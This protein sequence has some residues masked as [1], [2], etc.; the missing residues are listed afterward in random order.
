[1]RR[2]AILALC[3]FARYAAASCSIGVPPPKF[4]V[5][6]DAQCKY[7][8][9]QA[10]IK[11]V[12]SPTSCAPTI[13]VTNEHQPWNE[14]L[15]IDGRS[16]TLA[17]IAGGCGVSSTGIEGAPDSPATT[18]TSPQATISG[19]GKN[20]P[21]ITISGNSTVTLQNLE[22]TGG[23]MTENSQGAGINFTGSGSL[24]LNATTVDGNKADY[25]AGI[26]MSPSGSATLTLQAY[27]LIVNNQAATSGG[28]IRIEGN[29][30]L[31]AVSDQTIITDNT[32]LGADGYGGGIEIFAPAYANIGSPGYGLQGVV[33]GNTAAYGGGIAVH[34]T[35]DSGESAYLQMFTTVAERPVA[36]EDNVATVMGGGIYLEP[37][38][39]TVAYSDAQMCLFDFRVDGN[40]APEGAAIALDNIKQ[41]ETGDS[42]G[43]MNLNVAY[44]A[45]N[46]GPRPPADFNAIPCAADTACN[47][48]SHNNPPP[49]P[50]PNPYKPTGGVIFVGNKD[51]FVG[52]RFKLQ[53][54]YADYGMHIL[55]GLGYGA[56]ANSSAYACLFT[57][58][59][60]RLN[61]VFGDGDSF[62]F[63]FINCTMAN[64]LDEYGYVFR[65]GTNAE[66][67]LH[68]D[69]FDE[70]GS[71]TVFPQ[72]DL[73]L[74]ASYILANDTSTLSTA[75]SIVELSASD[76]LFVDAAHG[77]Y[78]LIAAMQ[79][80]S[81]IATAAI[82]FA[83][84]DGDPPDDLDGNTYGQDVPIIPN[85][86]GTRD[87]GAYEAQPITDRI[88]G[89]AFGDILLIAK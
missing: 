79:N 51:V 22:V 13:Y 30:Q 21:V 32:A 9:I 24:T 70:F 20:A 66:L 47:E 52:Y 86:Y 28:G 80:F 67:D 23:E 35:F 25:G 19:A 85:F 81:L 64:N 84:E 16:L 74:N 78:H 43:F 63:K 12:P 73:T 76:P 82:D 59:H 48:I 26:A 11:D 68:K 56:S 27:S 31:V 8:T 39:V 1:M 54:N 14:A 41:D 77:N 50:I 49:D 7:T 29:T 2:T 62:V 53:D 58:N 38:A 33:S 60:F 65:L 18:P 75:A 87:L 3:L 83:P 15:T 72:S 6:S 55:G 40:T 89:D 34:G 45:F 44:N 88:F 10:A 57:D 5:G 36:V 69:I 61:D 4:Y 42:I 46:C 17:G 37:A 71:W